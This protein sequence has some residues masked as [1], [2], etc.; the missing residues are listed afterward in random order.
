[1]VSGNTNAPIIMI[2]EKGA[3]LI[4]QYWRKGRRGVSR[5][6]I[7][8]HA[9][10]AGPDE[11]SLTDLP[12][13]F[14]TLQLTFLDWQYKTEP[15]DNYCLG[16]RNKRC[17]WPRGKV[18]GGSSVLNAMLYIRGNKK[19]YD[20]WRDLGNPGWGYEDVLPYFKKSEDMRIPELRD[21]YY[22]GKNGYL[23]VEHFRYHS[24][25]A[26]WYLDAAREMGYDVLDVN[27]A[28][29]TGFT[30]SHGTLKEGLRCSTAKGFLRPIKN[31]T[32]LHISMHS[33]DHVAM[34][35][36]TYLFDPLDKNKS[37]MYSFQ[38]PEVFST[39]T[40]N[41]F[42]QQHDGPIYWLPE[43]EVMGFVSTKYQ[44][45]DEDW[46]DIQYFITAYADSTDGGLFSKRAIG[47]TDEYYSAVYEEILYKEAFN[48][49][50]LLM[51]PKSK[52]RLRLKDNNPNSK[53]LIYPNYY[54]DPQ[55]I[56]VMVEG[57]KIGH[58]LTR[59]PALQKYNTTI[60]KLKMPDCVHLEFLSDEYW[61]CQA[62]HYT[63]TIYHP[64]GTAKMGPDDDPMAVV[65]SR[66]N[67][68][69]VKNLRVVDCSVMPYI[70]TG[71]TNAPVIM[72]AEKA[73][74]MIKE[75]WGVLNRY[76]DSDE[77]TS[78][79]QD[80]ASVEGLVDSCPNNLEGFSG[81]IFLTLINTLMATKCSLGSPNQYPEDFGPKLEDGDVFDF[82]VVGAGSGG[83]VVANKLSENKDWKVL[84]PALLFSVIDSKEDWQFQAQHEEGSCLG[85]K[86]QRC[87]WPRGK[88]LGGCSSINAMLYVKGSKRDYDKW[89]EIGNEGWSWEDFY[90]ALSDEIWND[91]FFPDEPVK[92]SI[93]EGAIELG[94]PSLLEEQPDNPLGYIDLPITVENGVRM[95]AAKAFL[96][97]VKDRK[98]LRIAVNAM[99]ENILIDRAT[100]AAKGVQVKIGERVI[101]VF[102]KK[103]VI[104]SAGAINSPQLLMTSGIGPKD[105]LQ[106]LGI[107]VIQ[108]LPAVGKNLQDHLNFFGFFVKLDHNAEKPHSPLTNLDAA[109]EYITRRTG[110]LATI[111]MTNLV[112]FINTRNDSIYPNAQLHH[113]LLPSGDQYLLPASSQAMGFNEEVIQKRLEINQRNPALFITS[114][115]LN[116]KSKGE[117]VLKSKDIYDAPVIHT[118]Y[119]SDPEED[120]L[121]THLEAIRYC[122]ALLKTESMSK[123]N[124][125]LIREALPTCEQYPFDSDE[126][127]KCAVR[128]LSGTLYHP[129]GTCKM[130]PKDD[131]TAVV[132]SELRVKGVKGLRVADAS[133]MPTVISGN[134][135]APTM[136]IGR[137]AGVMITEYWSQE[138]ETVFDFIIVG[139]G[140]AGCAV[141]NQITENSLW[142]VLLIEAGDYPS[143][144]TEVPGLFTTLIGSEED[145]HFLMLKEPRACLAFTDSRCRISRGKV[146]GGTSTIENLLYI[147]GLPEDYNED[148]FLQWDGSIFRDIFLH[149]ENYTGS[150]AT[151]YAYGQKGPIHLEDATYNETAKDMLESYY[152]QVGSK[153]MPKRHSLGMIS[154]FLMR[155]DGERYNMAKVF[156][157]S[158]K[159]RPNLFFSK[160]TIAESIGISE[161]VDKR[162]TGVNVSIDGVK[163]FL[164]AKKEVI[165]A[166]GPI[167]NPKLLLLSGIGEKKYLEKLKLPYNAYVPAVGKYLQI[168]IALPI[169]VS[170]NGTCP[171]CEPEKYDESDLYRD[172]FEYILFRSG[173]FAH[174][175]VN[176]F[177]NYI[178]TKKQALL[179]QT[180]RFNIC[181]SK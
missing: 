64:I 59:M 144:N 172:T 35:G 74:D 76:Y 102:A 112:G 126:Y 2:G 38:L 161:P 175:N 58:N 171:G 97:K 82:I 85:F 16:L 18:L 106:S 98:N 128:H 123:H 121:N 66:L 150:E 99:T 151:Y 70:T 21:D 33:T 169:Y 117:V 176:N 1:M 60:N 145:W 95:N 89:Y 157:T 50:T 45:E 29:Q 129:V 23:T 158:I 140:A 30:L 130:G 179:Y 153:R 163:L 173:R 113:L 96:G 174:T 138:Q 34:G 73:S 75:D 118:K 67:V 181:I 53:I 86:N 94:Y 36:A 133:I 25:M 149:L 46:P 69:G 17:N 87:K 143:P 47:L 63:L 134:T 120:D 80:G 5:S 166:A 139:G 152:M 92:T 12:L 61:A 164:R 84:T 51:R 9:R 6:N 180:Y 81:H 57:A 119:L 4:K 142:S 114:L 135:N 3:D 77:E 28:Q 71:N 155:K 42:A 162:A 154:H 156:L 111:S 131:P 56:K 170:I 54:S 65:D 101:K 7:L 55:D 79:A 165:L 159:D 14:P 122:Q 177:V 107:E 141:A 160:N 40:I 15:G 20:R 62:K 8:S 37:S 137:K 88:F 27:G 147:N 13:M 48:I 90:I 132:D 105:H 22:H 10:K 93:K 11:V 31:R 49:I 115:V 52:G 32:N 68:R 91:M 148:G 78:D 124:P 136:M 19:D 168:H 41:K 43:S 125:E 83:S 100:K 24:P 26:Q 103:E 109:Y 108:D 146:L 110:D 39:E 104:L 127:W 167:N 116:P 72:I 178:L 44:D